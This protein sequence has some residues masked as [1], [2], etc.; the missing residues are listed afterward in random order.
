MG[1]NS[2]LALLAA[3][4]ATLGGCQMTQN[5]IDGTTSFV[6]NLGSG[7]ALRDSQSL[8]VVDGNQAI[9]LR[10]G[11][12]YVDNSFD[13]AA[14]QQLVASGDKIDLTQDLGFVPTLA[15]G[16]DIRNRAAEIIATAQGNA[17]AALDSGVD[18]VGQ[19][20][21]FAVNNV[22]VSA[23]NGG[24]STITLTGVSA[25]RVEDLQ[26]A[27]ERFVPAA[28]EASESVLALTPAQLKG[29]ALAYTRQRA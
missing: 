11:K 16:Q 21:V 4:A 25:V 20:S 22:T 5:V 3:A 23:V 15:A 19:T 29:L 18:Q 14:F 8:L 6:S 26:K 24:I 7:G 10:G 9:L 1:R 27:S 2:N 17:Q 13:A 28:V 12:V